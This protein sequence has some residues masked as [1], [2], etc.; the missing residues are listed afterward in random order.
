MQSILRAHEMELQQ[1]AAG[2]MTQSTQS[3]HDVGAR[4]SQTWSSQ[5][6][7]GVLTRKDGTSSTSGFLL[8]SCSVTPQDMAHTVTVADLSQSLV[9]H[10]CRP[11]RIREISGYENRE[12]VHGVSPTTL[13]YQSSALPAQVVLPP[14]HTRL[15]R[16]GRTSAADIE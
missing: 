13:V 11:P 8:G 9:S 15:A 6:S 3:K 4:N 2:H 12:D 16:N 5:L 7:P 1:Q 10:T 14:P